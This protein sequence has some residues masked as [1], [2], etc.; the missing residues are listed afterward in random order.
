MEV[1]RAGIWDYLRGQYA[2]LTEEPEKTNSVRVCQ[3][4]RI[5]LR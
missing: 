3:P 5:V 2:L 4:R 1:K